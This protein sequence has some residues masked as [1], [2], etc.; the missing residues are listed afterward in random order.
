MLLSPSHAHKMG[1]AATLTLR[2]CIPSGCDAAVLLRSRILKLRRGQGFLALRIHPA[3]G[4]DYVSPIPVP[5][6]IGHTYVGNGSADIRVRP[7][8]WLNPFASVSASEDDAKAHFESYAAARADLRLW[9]QPLAGQRLVVE[10]GIRGAHAAV[11]LEIM[12]SLSK[13]EKT[14]TFTQTFTS[15]LSK[16]FTHNFTEAAATTYTHLTTALTTLRI[17]RLSGSLMMP[18]GQVQEI[19]APQT[20]R[21]RR[22]AAGQREAP[23][24]QVQVCRFCRAPWWTLRVL[25]VVLALPAWQG[26]LLV[27]LA[28]ACLRWCPGVGLLGGLP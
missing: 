16:T 3:V 7:S 1:Q 13:S 20:D 4:V 8:P 14:S 28:V 22:L 25:L 9:V 19:L 11:L 24:D 15:N 27:S 10:P 26:H 12:Q 18:A 2:C 17:K 5:L 21:L 6:P 23:V